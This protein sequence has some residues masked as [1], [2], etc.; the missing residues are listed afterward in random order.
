MK[1]SELRAESTDHLAVML[2]DKRKA[3]LEWRMKSAAGEGLNPHEA[4]ATRRDIARI[5]TILAE[6]SG[7]NAPASTGGKE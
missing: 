3:L 2:A 4:N 1:P 5:L 7:E 6:R